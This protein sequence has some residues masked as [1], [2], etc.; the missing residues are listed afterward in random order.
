MKTKNR[1]MDSIK[2]NEDAI[3]EKL[4]NSS[5]IQSEASKLADDLSYLKPDQY[6]YLLNKFTRELEGPALANLLIVSAINKVN[7]NPEYLA[8]SI[9]IV[10]DVNNVYFACKYQDENSL[11]TLLDTINSNYFSCLRI[12]IAPLRIAVELSLKFNKMQPE[13]KKAI[14]LATLKSQYYY[15]QCDDVKKLEKILM[16]GIYGSPDKE[17][18]TDQNPLT[19]LPKKAEDIPIMTGPSPWNLSKI[20]PKKFDE[21]QLAEYVHGAINFGFLDKAYELLTEFRKKCLDNDKVD[22]ITREL[23]NVSIIYNNFV[24]NEKLLKLLPEN[25]RTPEDAVI[26][27]TMSHPHGIENLKPII[28]IK[29]INKEIHRFSAL[30]FLLWLKNSRSIPE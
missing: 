23:Y 16:E 3:I 30:E 9:K 10:D 6:D 25:M 8:R 29:I 12:E 11:Q 27:H 5:P 28:F 24:L 13:V 2:F 1:K 7:L 18:K 21:N 26:K 20:D 17:W 22:Q 19:E 4:E 15:E 14:N